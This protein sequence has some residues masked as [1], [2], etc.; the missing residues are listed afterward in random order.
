MKQRVDPSGFANP[1]RW[2]FRFVPKKLAPDMFRVELRYLNNIE[3]LKDPEHFRLA[4]GLL[5]QFRPWFK[6]MLLYTTDLRTKRI[7]VTERGAQ[8]LK[9][10]LRMHSPKPFCPETC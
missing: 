3:L 7:T 1:E 2:S 4:I 6:K 10:T 5:L 8:L 9:R